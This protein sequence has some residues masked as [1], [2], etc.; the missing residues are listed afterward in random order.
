M[1]DDDEFDW[2][3]EIPE[4]YRATPL[5]EETKTIGDLAKQAVDFQRMM[6]G[7]LRI[8]TEEA[9]DEVKAE[10]KTKLE[11]VGMVPLD[12]YTDYVKPKEAEHYKLAQPP[13]DA[14]ELELTQG[15]I[16][17]W[18]DDAFKDGLSQE[19]FEAR[20]Q[21]TIDNMRSNRDTAKANYQTQD[22]ALREKWGPHGYE[23]QKQRALAAAM[24]MGGQELYERLKN[25]PDPQVL[26]AFGEV[27]K[28]FEEKGMGDLEQPLSLPETKDE[29]QAKLTDIVNNADSAFN[30]RS[31]NPKAYE[32]QAKE[33]MRLRR[34][35]AGEPANVA[36]DMFASG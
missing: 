4:E 15:M 2:R 17:N 7:M 24:R 12:S 34:I 16:D 9:S 6:G 23:A 11:K 31:R 29:A 28:E 21:R 27:G 5:I 32:M 8:P 35:A 26:L 33:V 18:K 22:N 36:D 14:V 3:G 10:F 25:N 1:S 30:N 19:Q 20:A 13:A